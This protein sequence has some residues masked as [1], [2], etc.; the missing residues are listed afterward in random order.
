MAAEA[1]E[2]VDPAGLRIHGDLHR[3]N[4]LWTDDGLHVVDLDDC[5]TGPAVQDL[6]MF[7]DPGEEA[8]GEFADLLRGYREFATLDSREL[9]LVEALRT[10]RLVHHTGWIARRWQDPAFPRAFPWFA[11]HGF[12]ERH[13]L[14]LREQISA[15]REAPTVFYDSL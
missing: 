15:M 3:G 13:V 9:Q 1:L 7:L 14:D 8:Q 2:A 6:W 4:L 12:W 5:M 11:E 10:L